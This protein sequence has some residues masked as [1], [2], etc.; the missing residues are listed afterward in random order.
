M[1]Q[2]I[3]H[4]FRVII[5]EIG[6]EWFLV[7]ETPERMASVRWFV[8][9]FGGVEEITETTLKSI[10]PDDC[11]GWHRYFEDWKNQGILN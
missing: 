2:W 5:D 8:Q 7:S 10:D 6:E 3:K 1:E 9:N 4:H 11:M